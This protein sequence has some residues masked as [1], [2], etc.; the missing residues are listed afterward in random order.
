MLTLIV[1]AGACDRREDARPPPSPAQV[2]TTAASRALDERLLGNLAT[3]RQWS[4][5]ALKVWLKNP[6]VATTIISADR[7]SVR[8][9]AWG[10]NENDYNTAIMRLDAGDVLYA[11]T[12]DEFDELWAR[13]AAGKVP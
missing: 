12:K 1:V 8:I 10:H 4:S 3:R 7:K 6:T 11:I 13:A 9:R 2:T 5:N